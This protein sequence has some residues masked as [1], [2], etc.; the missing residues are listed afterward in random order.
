MFRN[1]RKVAVAA[2]AGA[3]AVRLAVLTSTVEPENVLGSLLLTATVYSLA[4]AV[5]LWAGRR[6]D[7]L[8]SLTTIAAGAILVAVAAACLPAQQPLI[9]TREADTEGRR[10]VRPFTATTGGQS[11]TAVELQRGEATA[12]ASDRVFADLSRLPNCEH[13]LSVWIARPFPPEPHTSDS[14]A[15]ANPVS[16]FIRASGQPDGPAL[17]QFTFPAQ[18]NSGHAQWHRLAARIPAEAR[19]LV[20]EVPAGPGLPLPSDPVWVDVQPPRPVR[21]GLV[22][23]A[24]MIRLVRALAGASV[25]F[26]I[27]VIPLL[28]VTPRTRSTF[29]PGPRGQAWTAGV[30]AAVAVVVL[31]L[32]VLMTTYGMSDDYSCLYMA[33][34]NP[35]VSRSVLFG[36]GRFILGLL[37]PAVFAQIDTIAAFSYL[38]AAA[39]LGMAGL[40]AALATFVLRRGWT[41][42]QAVALAFLI[43]ST[44][45]AA[46]AVGWTQLF[47]LSWALLITWLA[48]WFQQQMTW[49]PLWKGIVCGLGAIA[50]LSATFW[51][52][53]PCAMFYL[54]WLIL[55]QLPT[56]TV[57]PRRKIATGI[58]GLLIFAAGALLPYLSI[59][60][61]SA[62]NPRASAVTNVGAKL[63]WFI[64]EPLRNASALFELAPGTTVSTIVV[65]IVILA[66]I[67]YGW[68]REWRSVTA[69]V[70]LL[71]AAPIVYLPNLMIADN[72]AAY[73]SLFSLAAL[74]VVLAAFALRGVVPHAGI[75][76]ALMVLVAARA[77]TVCS[78]Q[79]RRG[80]IAPQA[81]ELRLTQQILAQ[82]VA[83]NINGIHVIQPHWAHCA[84]ERVLYDEFGVA[85]TL[86]PWTPPHF[87]WAATRDGALPQLR[88]MRDLPVTH[89]PDRPTKQRRGELQIDLH[90]LGDWRAAAEWFAPK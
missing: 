75:L 44:P 78:E 11:R 5:A 61:Q 12:G 41:G 13:A 23:P 86:H 83:Q 70:G 21:L 43:C 34:H 79:T 53:Q 24:G 82:S 57:E 3:T 36:C 63:Q 2:I 26:A 27:A 88:G 56:R 76:S 81:L 65:V 15:N 29:T 16:V 48:F 90:E 17:T 71:A 35:E 50:S 22:W 1:D 87:I 51:M 84:A 77:A 45:S 10:W 73:R 28:L 54:V 25:F 69:L 38:R 37:Y 85:T 89:S 20:I 8:W 9:L 32:P 74:L 40:G 31:H 60:L 52:Y 67:C 6:R 14:A 33:H 58:R 66:I 30:G 49:K 59:V 46:L 55:D 18:S 39:V 80:I 62:P 42:P 4:A 7:E 72:W 47:A 68:R 64:Q 19:E